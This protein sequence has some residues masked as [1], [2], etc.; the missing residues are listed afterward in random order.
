M[1]AGRKG[2]KFFGI[3]VN[4][5]ALQDFRALAWELSLLTNVSVLHTYAF[6]ELRLSRNP[7]ANPCARSRT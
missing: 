6:L 5:K 4:R 3:N 1:L 7:I 2:K